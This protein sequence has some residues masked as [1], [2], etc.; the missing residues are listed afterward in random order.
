MGGWS[1]A[2]CTLHDNAGRARSVQLWFL[3]SWG[4][5]YHHGGWHG[6]VCTR[7][8]GWSIQVTIFS[9]SLSFTVL[10][11]FL[12]LIPVLTGTEKSAVLC[13]YDLAYLHACLC[14]CVCLNDRECKR[15][16]GVSTTELVGRMLLMTR[17]HHQEKDTENI[18]AQP[19]LDSFSAGREASP[20]TGVSRYLAT[21]KRLLQFSS[22]KE[23]KVS[24]H[25]P[26][27]SAIVAAILRFF[28]CLLMLN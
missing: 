6:L 2:K 9:L 25:L 11:L 4:W 7:Q 22:M 21:T 19:E 20:Y 5:Y 15:T 1:C 8:G 27:H 24:E 14:P 12:V 10:F 13:F 16:M 26:C 18:L 28:T 23:P 3:C 17:Q